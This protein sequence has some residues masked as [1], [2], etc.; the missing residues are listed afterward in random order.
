M[1]ANL[2]KA[3]RKIIAEENRRS[4]LTLSNRDRDRFLAMLDAD[5]TPNRA[6]QAAAKRQRQRII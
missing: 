1:A 3:A 2:T 6:L 5:P 4:Q